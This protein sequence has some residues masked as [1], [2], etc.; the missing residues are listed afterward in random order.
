[1]ARHEAI[2]FR[3]SCSMRVF[4]CAHACASFLSFGSIGRGATGS[5]CVVLFSLA[6]VKNTMMHIH[7][8]IVATPLY[9]AIVL[10]VVLLVLFH[11]AGHGIAV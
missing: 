9:T 3:V 7:A 8:C 5:V 6:V 10:S 1:M 4:C 2:W 11:F